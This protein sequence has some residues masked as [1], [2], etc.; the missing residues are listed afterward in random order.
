LKCMLEAAD[1]YG[2][3]LDRLPGQFLLIPHAGY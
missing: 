1:V 3:V 2:V